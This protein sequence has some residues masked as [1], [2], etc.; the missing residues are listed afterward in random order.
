MFVH[1]CANAL[2]NFKG[3]EGL[4]LFCF[5]YYFVLKKFNYIA[6]DASTLHLKLDGNGRYNYFPTSTPLRRTPPITMI[7]LL[8]VI[9]C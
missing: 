7:D 8:Q 9:N 4:A 3:L 6:K 2:W 1:D 5:G